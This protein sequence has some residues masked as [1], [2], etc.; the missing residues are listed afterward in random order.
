MT[1]EKYIS[2]RIPCFNMSKKGKSKKDIQYSKGNKPYDQSNIKLGSKSEQL[3]EK[4]PSSEILAH[5]RKID[6]K[7]GAKEYLVKLLEISL[8]LSRGINPYELNEHLTN[9]NEN[10]K[11]FYKRFSKQV[12]E[13]ENVLSL[14]EEE[15]RYSSLI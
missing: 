7:M 5:L 3:Y 14:R 9:L 2:N 4:E 1:T 12:S 10:N 8:D 6:E 15:G 11:K 13:L